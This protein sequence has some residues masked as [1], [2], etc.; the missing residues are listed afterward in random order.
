MTPDELL[1][2]SDLP[3]EE[4]IAKL[5]EAVTCYEVARKLVAAKDEA[6]R[7]AVRGLWL[8]IEERSEW[9]VA[10][11]FARVVEDLHAQID[12]SW[13]DIQPKSGAIQDKINAIT[14]FAD[15]KVAACEKEL[16]DSTASW[17]AAI[18]V[19][20]DER[21]TALARVAELEREVADADK[22]TA[23]WNVLANCADTLRARDFGSELGPLDDRVIAMAKAL[24]D[25]RATARAAKA[26]GER[27]AVAAQRILDLRASQYWFPRDDGGRVADA[28]RT[29][30]AAIR[31]ARLAADAKEG[32]L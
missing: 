24:D 19:V 18:S 30:H 10:T 20:Y 25:A 6:L 14:E 9:D 2:Y 17:K 23:C 22:N 11:G 13:P 16:C 27:L 3:R 15:A 5:T 26:D 32:K 1:A 28:C 31:A 8:I 21:D 4:L 29:L 7:N 12:E